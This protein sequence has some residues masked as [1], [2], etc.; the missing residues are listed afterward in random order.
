[1]ITFH[2]KNLFL[3]NITTCCTPMLG[4]Y[5]GDGTTWLIMTFYKFG[6]LDKYIEQNTTITVSILLT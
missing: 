1:M 2:V 6:S 4:V 5:K 3:T